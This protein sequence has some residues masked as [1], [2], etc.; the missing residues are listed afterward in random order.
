M[1][2]AAASGL[3]SSGVLGRG[4]QTDGWDT[5]PDKRTSQPNQWKLAISAAL[6]CQ[7]LPLPVP[8]L[9]WLV[10]KEP[11][12]LVR[13]LRTDRS[14]AST[15]RGPRRLGLCCWSEPA[16]WAAT[17]WNVK[18]CVA[19]VQ[20]PS[21]VGWFKWGPR[22]SS[23]PTTNQPQSTW[24]AKHFMMTLWWQRWLDFANSGHFCLLQFTNLY[25][26]LKH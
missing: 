1:W 22:D 15:G 21:F 19:H 14:G 25:A 5:R 23:V 11:G 6:S 26:S 2:Q 3:G 4:H 16:L 9:S 7:C 12:L 24:K 13:G 18:C 17:L 10:R 20:A 8:S